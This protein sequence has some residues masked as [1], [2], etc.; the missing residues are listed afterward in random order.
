MTRTRYTAQRAEKL[1]V[2][3]PRPNEPVRP[4]HGFFQA[5]GL[6]NQAIAGSPSSQK[7][8]EAIEPP[9]LMNLEDLT[10]KREGENFLWSTKNPLEVPL[11]MPAWSKDVPVLMDKIEAGYKLR[12]EA[13]LPTDRVFIRNEDYTKWKFPNGLVCP[14]H[15][16]P[17]MHKGKDRDNLFCTVTGCNRKMTRKKKQNEPSDQ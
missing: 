12:Q 17:M 15:G 7:W 2:P 4:I 9:P 5:A 16:N 13:G 14:D 1:P 3:M 6:A 11:V 10:T 8:S